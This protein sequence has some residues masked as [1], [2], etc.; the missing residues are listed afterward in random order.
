VC[1]CFDLN[2]DLGDGGCDVLRSGD[3]DCG[4]YIGGGGA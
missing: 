2:L 1:C 3:E 4:E